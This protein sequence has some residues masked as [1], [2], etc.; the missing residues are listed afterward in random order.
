MWCIMWLFGHIINIKEKTINFKDF[1]KRMVDG[2][3]KSKL[4]VID[5]EIVQEAVRIRVKD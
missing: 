1:V 5:A 3:D 4:D 2:H